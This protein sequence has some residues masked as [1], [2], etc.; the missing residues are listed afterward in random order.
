MVKTAGKRVVPAGWTMMQIDQHL[1][2]AVPHCWIVEWI[3]WILE[4][5][6]EPVQFH[7]GDIIISHAPG[8][9]TTIKPEALHEYAVS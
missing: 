7:D 8:A 4:I 6:K 3:P 2:A 5:F 9:S 1:A